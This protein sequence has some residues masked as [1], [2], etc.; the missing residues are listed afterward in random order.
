MSWTFRFVWSLDAVLFRKGGSRSSTGSSHCGLLNCFRFS[1]GIYTT[2]R[3]VG[4]RFR[5]ARRQVSEHFSEGALCASCSVELRQR[6]IISEERLQARRLRRQQLH[7]GIEHIQL[8][9]CASIQARLGQTQRFLGLLDIFLLAL[10]QFAILLQNRIGLLY[11]Q[12]D[13]P[14]VIVVRIL[15][16]EKESALLNDL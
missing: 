5:R 11:L 12:F 9:S 7:L 10:N 4:L 13:L 15:G 14:N 1:F 16:F 6:K 8:N 3:V 2:S